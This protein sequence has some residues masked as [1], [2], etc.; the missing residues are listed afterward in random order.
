[1]GRLGSRLVFRPS[2]VDDRFHVTVSVSAALAVKGDGPRMDRNR[3]TDLLA[4]AKTGDVSSF[5]EALA[6]YLPALLAYGRTICGDHH[7]AEDV[8]QESVLIAYRNLGHFFPETDFGAW[9]RA[10]VR[11]KA[12]EMRRTLRKVRL[13]FEESFERV[14]EDPGPEAVSPWRNALSECLKQ[15]D[16]RAGQV[17]RGFYFEGLDLLQIAATIKTTLEGTKQ[18]LYRTRLILR[19]CVRKR[20]GMEGVS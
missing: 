11:R 9:L 6:P 14:F 16:G 20:V 13:G 18:L 1:M 8:V 4:K 19:T 10:I 5:E 3:E 2:R 15:L 12:L 7:A 17:V